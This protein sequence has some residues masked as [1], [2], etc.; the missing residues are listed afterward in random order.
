MRLFNDGDV[1]L[2]KDMKGS[3]SLYTIISI[4]IA[5]SG[6]TSYFV[7]EHGANRETRKSKKEFSTTSHNKEGNQRL[8]KFWLSFG[9][10]YTLKNSVGDDVVAELDSFVY[11]NGTLILCFLTPKKQMLL[12]SYTEVEKEVNYCNTEH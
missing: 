11:D 4:T 5:T 10:T 1:V 12:K 7:R 8:Y 3:L 2:Y 9:E 6:E